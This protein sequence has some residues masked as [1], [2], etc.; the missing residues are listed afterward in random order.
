[1]FNDAGKMQVSFGAGIP[2]GP[3]NVD[4]GFATH[5]RTLSGAKGLYMATSL[6]FGEY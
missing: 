2:A 3:V 5:N 4:L 1:V 6:R